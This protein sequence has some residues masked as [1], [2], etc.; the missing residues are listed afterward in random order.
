MNAVFVAGR[1][2][3]RTATFAHKLVGVNAAIQRSIA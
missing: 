3:Q 2:H 1:F